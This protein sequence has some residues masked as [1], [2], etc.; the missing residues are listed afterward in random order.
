MNFLKLCLILPTES[1]ADIL[2]RQN[3][4]LFGQ[5]TQISSAGM[6]RSQH[7]T[8]DY[9]FRQ[10]SQLGIDWRFARINNERRGLNSGTGFRRTLR[11]APDQLLSWRCT[12][13]F[14]LVEWH[15]TKRSSDCRNRKKAKS[16][17]SENQIAAFKVEEVS[18]V[19]KEK[20]E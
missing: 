9:R 4:G 2:I 6:K 1:D 20:T 17:L 12:A 13:G 14:P 5:K 10:P 18:S 3:R 16:S 7:R 11:C 8:P 19:I 15:Q